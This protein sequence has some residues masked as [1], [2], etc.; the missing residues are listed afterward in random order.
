MYK[1]TRGLLQF[2][3]LL[4]VIGG[5]T[6]LAQTPPAS[7]ANVLDFLA[8][9]AAAN[10]SLRLN[11]TSEARRWLDSIPPS[12]RNWE[13]RLLDARADSSIDRYKADGWNPT[14]IDLSLDHSQLAV[15]GSDGKVRIFSTNPI[16]LVHELSVS[17][18]SIY[19]ARF[20]PDGSHVAVC[21]RDS[22]LSLW[23]IASG[24]QSW[25]K[26]SGGEGLA[27]VA[28]HPN[29]KQLLFCSW[30]R[31]SKT[32]LGIVST[33]DVVSGDQV[34]K[35][36]FGVKPIV[37][38]RYS[39]N[40]DRFA[41]GTWDAQIG[42]W[43]TD[44]P[45]QPQI[46][47]FADRSQYSAIHDI[48]FSP[49]GKLLAAATKNGTPRIWTLDGSQPPIDL[50]GHNNAVFCVSFS[51]DG[52]RVLSGGSDGVIS[53]W[54]IAQRNKTYR[55][56]GHTNRVGSLAIDSRNQKVYSVSA[57]QTLRSWDL[58]ASESFFSTTASKYP[59]GIVVM[60]Q[61][62]MLVSGGLSDSIV[63]VW[64]TDNKE[65]VLEYPG[66]DGGVNYLDDN[67]SEWVVGG[68]WSGE[69]IVWEYK[70]GIVV[71]KFGSKETGGIQQCVLSNDSRWVVTATN[72]KQAVVWDV[73]SGELKKTIPFE[74]GCGAL[75][76]SSDNC[77]R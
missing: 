59:Y 3:L 43:P 31:G 29:G 34:W 28:F 44:S 15:A 54:D 62:K 60:D 48:A 61:G 49:D 1:R 32:V 6:G 17:T 57:D 67:G 45:E 68:N 10:A 14:R 8:P 74:V 38:A 33:W 23:D 11:E 50:Y 18:Q 13:W 12:A 26:A 70:T 21:S 58:D 5:S 72:K 63:S 55:F 36:E 37:A 24:K 16:A 7:E 39:P 41:V 65:L 40:G 77:W 73:H 64:D 52:K 42:I 53:V 22:Q 76:L 9:L 2:T 75:D 25:S 51:P 56:Y 66:T 4:S 71:R 35:T 19:A 46:L 47:D 27:D 20:S 69:L 30:Y